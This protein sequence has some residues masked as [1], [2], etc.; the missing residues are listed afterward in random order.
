MD[1][2][3]RKAARTMVLAAGAA[4]LTA[5]AAGQSLLWAAQFGSPAQDFP[6]GA[7]SDGTGGLFVT[8]MTGGPENHADAFVAR[9]DRS[10]SRLWIR[11]TG[12]N[13][14]EFA[15]AAAPGHEG[16]VIITGYTDGNLAGTS[17]GRSDVFVALYSAVGDVI[18]IRQIGGPENEQPWGLAADGHG[19]V[20]VAGLTSS[21]LVGSSYG[22]VDAF[23]ARFSSAGE[24]LWIR[25]FGTGVRDEASAL[26]PD[27]AG[28]VFLAGTTTGSLGGPN[29]EGNDAYLARFDAEGN[30]LWHRQF[31]SAST[32][33]ANALTHDGQGGVYVSGPVHRPAPAGWDTFLAR[34]SVDGAQEWLREFGTTA[35]EYAHALAPD[36]EGG[37]YIAGDTYGSLGGPSAG[38]SDTFLVKFNADGIQTW[39]HQHGTP[40][41]DLGRCIFADGTG[42]VF[43]ADQTDGG[44]AAPNAGGDDWYVLRYGTPCYFNC[45]GSSVAPT[46]NV[47]DFVCFLNR[48]GASDPYA[49]CDGSTTP[50]ILNVVDFVC[51]QNG[52]V[53]GCP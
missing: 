28:G 6:M 35:N 11:Q 26:L 37:V 39:A 51:F 23:I 5:P 47:A 21:S 13:S 50:P 9:L 48:Y 7:A 43:L 32:E 40:G 25:Q 33:W 20:F 15:T 30:R 16:G 42:G 8:G 1:F 19:G 38:D 2:A 45:D 53:Q 12:A 44:L 49:N 18:W 24:L 14:S 17:A 34:F 4:V 27:G 10:G 36:G 3:I 46:L 31:G 41:R 22:G 29:L 52:Y